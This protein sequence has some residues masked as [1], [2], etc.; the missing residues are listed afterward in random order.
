MVVNLTFHASGGRAPRD[1]SHG[2]IA[3]NAA[4]VLSKAVGQ[5]PREL[6]ARIAEALK[7]DEDVE[8]VD[9]AG[10]GFINLRLKASYWQR[11][12]LVML[13]EGTDFGRSR[14]G[15]GQ[16]GQCR[17][18]IGQPYGPVHV[19]RCRGAVVGDVLANLL[20]FAGY[21]VVKEYYINDAGA[22]IDVLARSVMLRYCGGTGRKHRRDSGGALPR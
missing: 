12:L 8:S 5:N 10:P 3:T 4:M 1:A 13:N 14:L 21:D 18:C 20:K 19:G 16:E 22:Q 9:V 15:A 2:D 7:A 17:I 11:E 6:A